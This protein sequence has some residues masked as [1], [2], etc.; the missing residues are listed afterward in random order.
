[1]RPDETSLLVEGFKSLLHRSW[2]KRVWIIQETANAQVAEIVCGGKSVSASVFAYMPR[3]LGITPDP[4]CQPILDIMPGSLRD[5]SW[6]AKKR[7]LYT[8]L[9]KFRNSEATDPRDKIYALLGIS[10]NTY[11]T[12]LLKTDYGKSPEDVVFNTT[13]FL[14]DFNKLKTPRFFDWTLPE[15]LGKLDKLAIEVLKCA[16][17][18]GHEVVVQLLLEK[19]AEVETKDGKGQT[20]LFWAAENGH[21]AVVQLL[22][23][24][25]AE[26]ETRD[27]NGQTPLFW[28]AENGHE[29]VVQLLIEK[30]AEVGQTPLLR[31][32]ENGHGA[33]V[34]LLLEKGAEVETR[35]QNGQTPLS[36]AAENGHEAVVQLLLEKGAKVETKAWNR[37]TPLFRAAQNGHKAVVQLLLEKGAEVETGDWNGQTPLSRAAQNRHEAVVQLL[38]E[39]GTKV[40]TKDRKGQT[41][42]F[43]AVQNKHKAVV[44]LLLEKGANKS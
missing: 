38:L 43:R 3:L 27:Q 37:Q 8:M 24:K 14:L 28:A 21:R 34:Q 18:T 6:W 9:D 13:S 11:D 31:A 20:P 32:A 36:Q 33:V 4:H 15:F 19:G 12:N 16:M 40:E 23:E 2:F 26:V 10:S 17:D 39:K 42:L 5:S 30:G 7:D 44:Q 41:P 1:M 22:L 25:G 29:A 35:D